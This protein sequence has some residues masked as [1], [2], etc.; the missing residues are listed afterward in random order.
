MLIFKAL[1]RLPPEVDYRYTLV[2]HGPDRDLFQ[3]YAAKK[4]L[5]VQF[6]DWMD[7]GELGHYYRTHSLYTAPDLHG[8]GGNAVMEAYLHGLPILTLDFVHKPNKK[9]NFDYV[10]KTHRLTASQIIDQTSEL[11]KEAYF[12]QR[13]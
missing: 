11:L 12:R 4:K 3:A 6:V 1:E 5:N 13:A 2:G 7:R 10:V 8:R 9:I